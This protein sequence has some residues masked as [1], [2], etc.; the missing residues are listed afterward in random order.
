MALEKEM[1]PEER[2][3]L[4]AIHG[5]LE[6]A[7]G[8][9]DPYIPDDMTDEEVAEEEPVFWAAQQVAALIGDG[10]WS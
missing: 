9:S 10:P 4:I 2:K 1:T 3:K 7:I 6:R 5:A 8:D